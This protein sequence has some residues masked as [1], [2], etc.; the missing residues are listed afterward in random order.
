MRPDAALGVLGRDTRHRYKEA[1]LEPGDAV[2][3]IG[4][5]IPFSDLADPSMAD[6]GSGPGPLVDDPEI[7]ADL[8]NAR[9]AG[10]LTDDPR[11][12]WGNAAI[13]G[14]GIGRP[15]TAPIIDP[16][17]N[18]LP[19]APASEATRNERTFTIAPETLVLASSA[20]APLLVAHGVPGAVVARR[21]TRFVVGLLGAVL[22][23]ASA[24]VLAISI[25]SRAA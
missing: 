7:A 10:L 14:F 5:A 8:A 24:M 9:A 19:L 18:P 1:R 3:V 15:T 6:A 11:V 17:A 2:T 22:A 20:E 23:I 21:Q 25:G 16:A 12:A 13:P 4:R